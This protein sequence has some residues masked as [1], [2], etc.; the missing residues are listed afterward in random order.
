MAPKGEGA[1]DSTGL[2][3]HHVS[4]YFVERKGYKR[5]RRRRWPKLTI[6]CHTPTHLI[7]A[8]RVVRGPSNDHPQFAPSLRQAVRHVRLARLLADAGYDSERNHVLC[9]KKLGIRSTAIALNRRNTGRRWPKTKYRRLMKRRF[10][11]RIY[12]HRWQVES[13][14][15]RHKRLLDSALRARNYAAQKRECLLRVLTHDLMI[16]KRAA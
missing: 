13:V 12:R 1:I 9:R 7:A 6:V 15:S 5:F 14:I 4:A 3:T 10:P 16:L 8:A 11:K 2:E